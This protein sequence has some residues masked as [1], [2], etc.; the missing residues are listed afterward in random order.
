MRGPSKTDGGPLVRSDTAAQTVL[1]NATSL[2]AQA[3][4]LSVSASIG[5][6]RIANGEAQDQ[7]IA[8]QKPALNKSPRFEQ[9]SESFRALQMENQRLRNLVVCLSSALLRNIASNLAGAPRAV[10]SAD[11]KQLNRALDVL[12]K[13]FPARKL[14]RHWPSARALSNFTAPISC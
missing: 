4:P 5:R 9:E 12:S 14:P 7:E 3:A 10:S 11:F 2:V 6:K 8:A 1:K 13:P